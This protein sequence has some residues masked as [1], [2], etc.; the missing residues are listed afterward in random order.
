MRRL[1]PNNYSAPGIPGKRL[2]FHSLTAVPTLQ[3][4]LWYRQGQIQD[5]GNRSSKSEGE[6]RI[7]GVKGPRIDG[8]TQEKVGEGSGTARRASQQQ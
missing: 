3:S 7:E 6:A 4:I 8:E 5:F 1:V 2:K